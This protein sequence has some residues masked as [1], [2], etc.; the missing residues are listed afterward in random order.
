MI[1]DVVL[2]I[3]DIGLTILGAVVAWVVIMWLDKNV[4]NKDRYK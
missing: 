3:S 1:N 2:S 4:F